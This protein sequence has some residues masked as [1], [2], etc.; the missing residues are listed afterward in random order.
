MGK[1]QQ[2]TKMDWVEE[3]VWDESE[4]TVYEGLVS[5]ENAFQDV[6][7]NFGQGE[8]FRPLAYSSYCVRPHKN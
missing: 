5:R 6:Q 2:R 8:S 7:S 1:K 3:L 4:C